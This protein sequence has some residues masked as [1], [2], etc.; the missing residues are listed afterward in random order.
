[1]CIKKRKEGERIVQSVDDRS[2]RRRHLCPY[3]EEN[4]RH[5]EKYDDA[6]GG[7]SNDVRVLRRPH[8]TTTRVTI[9]RSFS[10]SLSWLLYHRIDV[11]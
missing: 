9:V 3:G 8:V 7:T 10:P 1:M 6:V 5:K 11:K 4:K 2:V